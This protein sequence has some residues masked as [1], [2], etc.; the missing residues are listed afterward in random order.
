V[1]KKKKKKKKK[2]ANLAVRATSLLLLTAAHDGAVWRQ[3][4]VADIF[5]LLPCAMAQFSIFSSPYLFF[6]LLSFLTI[7]LSFL[8]FSVTFFSSSSFVFTSFVSPSCR[9][10]AASRRIFHFKSRKCVWYIS[11]KYGETR[12][13]CLLLVENGVGVAT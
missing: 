12:K 9:G 4:V 7:L 11:G 1:K 2:E 3:T 5:L 6:L 13:Y 10:C 8:P